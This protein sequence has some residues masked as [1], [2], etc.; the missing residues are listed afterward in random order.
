M[1]RDQVESGRPEDLLFFRR[2][3]PTS[4]PDAGSAT[5]TKFRL[6]NPALV[7]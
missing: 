2:P 7:R 1:M 3:I 5:I 4:R 6:T